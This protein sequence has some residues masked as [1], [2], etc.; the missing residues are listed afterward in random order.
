[1][2]KINELLRKIQEQESSKRLLIETGRIRIDSDKP[3][4]E[5]QK[6]QRNHPVPA[7]SD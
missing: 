3:E 6:M 2:E 7:E 1:M 5:K 4:S